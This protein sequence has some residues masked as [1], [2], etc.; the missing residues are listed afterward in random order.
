MRVIKKKSHYKI[1][2]FILV[3][4]L[5]TNIF[6]IISP[7]MQALAVEGDITMPGSG[8]D[9][10]EQVKWDSPEA[11]PE[12]GQVEIGTKVELYGSSDEEARIHYT[13]DGGD[14]TTESPI[15][16]Q[17]IEIIEDTTIKAFITGSG[18]LD[19]D[20]VEYTYIVEKS[21]FVEAMSVTVDGEGYEL[22]EGETL[23]LSAIV[24]PE[25]ATNKAVIW[26]SSDETVATISETGLVTAV[27]E[28]ETDIMVTTED[29]GHTGSIG[30]TVIPY[31]DD[32]IMLL[33]AETTAEGDINLIFNR[34]VVDP[35]GIDIEEQFIVLVDGQNVDVMAVMHG[36]HPDQVMLGLVTKITGGQAVTL[37]YIKSEEESKQIKSVEGEALESFE[38][39]DVFNSLLLPA[40]ELKLE[41]TDN[42]VGEPVELIF[43]G[44]ED[45]QNNIIEIYV[46]NQQLQRDNDY[47]IGVEIITIRAKFF[48]SVG[49][50]IIAVKAEGYQDAIVTLKIKKEST[51]PGPIEDEDIVLEIAGEGVAHSKKYT[52]SQ[53]EAMPQ[54]QEI[55]SSINTW[56]SKQWYVG[57]G[58]ALSY[59]FSSEQ[60][61]IKSGA[62]LIKF[63]SEDGY[64]MTLTAEELL[65]D[66]RYCFPNFKTGKDGDGHTPGSTRGK[67]EVETILALTSTEG[68]N[69]G[70]M[71]KLDALHLMLGQRTVTEQTGPLFVKNINKIEVLTRSVSKWDAPEAEPRSGTVSAGT[72]VRLKNKNMDQDKIHYTTDGST[73][74]IDSPIYNWI[75]KRWWATRGDGTVE[76]INRPIEITKDTVIK[77]VT[78]GP[79][80]RNSDVA[81]F[82]YK[83][84]G[85]QP[86]APDTSDEPKPGEGGTISLG[87]DIVTA[88]LESEELQFSDTI[89]HWAQDNIKKLVT[90]GAINGYPD[91]SFKPDNDITRAEF[92]TV[93]IR[94]LE[95]PLRNGKTFTDTVDHWACDMIS[96]AAHHGIVNGYDDNTF[97]PDEP[98]TREQMAVMIIRVSEPAPEEGELN[99]ID[100][101]RISDWARSFMITAVKNEIINGYPDNTIR[102]QG[103]ATRAEAVTII[104]REM[105]RREKQGLI[106]S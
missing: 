53:L 94:M 41:T 12:S 17:P 95:L 18:R 27:A 100:S 5:L 28:G 79:G 11:V 65:D 77:A 76:E 40:P 24:E 93:L 72:E 67:V 59:L 15:Y 78:I 71:N 82:T 8:L 105:D 70:Y 64:Y 1:Y 38:S 56:P 103:L 69:P 7:S 36:N 49:D 35:G 58:V 46:D 45:W 97:G 98:I 54:I 68:D 101:D 23:Q 47:E 34:D 104:V 20:M 55:Y 42:F 50:Y 32:V 6:V 60:A 66:Y 57:K 37:K 2:S 80:K 73:P 102:P 91:N 43:T 26:S 81:T 63:T 25:N 4:L 88:P 31:E 10:P 30:I 99:F 92:T 44:D 96:T 85:T 62:T 86:V 61:D 51:A 87:D 106:I 39:V 33:E 84:A 9:N 48:T 13:L 90:L 3:A 21:D 75:A 83:V 52:Q 14:P 89:N 16:D 22:E 74:T 29:G 19:S